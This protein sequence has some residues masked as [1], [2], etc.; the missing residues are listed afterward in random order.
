MMAYME[1]RGP[2]GAAIG[3]CYIINKL[4]DISIKSIYHFICKSS[5][6]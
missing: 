6:C 1:L 4:I 5:L 3:A 2:A